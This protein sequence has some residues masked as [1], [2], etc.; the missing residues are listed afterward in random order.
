MNRLTC[1]RSINN[2]RRKI[3]LNHRLPISR[4][5]FRSRNAGI[6]LTSI[7]AHTK[8]GGFS[9]FCSLLKMARKIF[10]AISPHVFRESFR[11]SYTGRFTVPIFLFSSPNRPKLMARWSIDLG[12]TAP[13]ARSR[14]RHR[15]APWL[16][17]GVCW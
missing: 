12:L 5:K 13:R 11:G 4:Y 3:E 17:D 6:Y 1:L 2:T 10:H 15:S 7:Y 16:A 8:F 14:R 9:S